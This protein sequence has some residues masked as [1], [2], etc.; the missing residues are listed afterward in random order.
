M[1]DRKL[2]FFLVLLL[3]A[4]AGFLV[5]GCNGNGAQEILSIQVGESPRTEYFTNEPLDV[6]GGTITVNY[7]K[8]NVT[9]E[10]SDPGV[11]FSGFESY[12]AGTKRVT[13]EYSGFKAYFNVTVTDPEIDSVE[14][15]TLPAQ[16]E[17]YVQDRI[18]VS[19][20]VLLVKFSSGYTLDV[21]MNSGNVTLE[22]DFGKAAVQTDVVV[23]Y[24]GIPVSFPVKVLDIY[25]RSIQ[26]RT[27]PKTVYYIDES[28][29][30][31]EGRLAL[32]Y[33]NGTEKI[34]SLDDDAVSV[35]E[36]DTS[37]MGRHL[38]NVK[39]GSFRTD[40]SVAVITP[41]MAYVYTH[42]GDIKTVDWNQVIPP[43]E[44]AEAAAAIALVNS[45][46]ELS[47]EEKAFF[48][49]GERDGILGAGFGAEFAAF[50]T[51]YADFSS[52]LT[53]DLFLYFNFGR[54]AEFEAFVTDINNY[55]EHLFNKYEKKY[56]DIVLAE[57][58]YKFTIGDILETE[59]LEYYDLV[60]YDYS[61]MLLALDIQE[62]VAASPLSP[63][64]ITG[65]NFTDFAFLGEASDIIA[66]Y[67][68]LMLNDAWPLLQL[69]TGKEFD[70]Y[71]FI[72]IVNE[73][74]LMS[75]LNEYPVIYLAYLL[76]DAYY[77]FQ[78]GYMF[79]DYTLFLY[80]YNRFEDEFNAAQQAVRDEFDALIYE[81]GIT[82]RDLRGELT[83]LFDSVFAEI[84]PDETLW[85]FGA[86]FADY[87]AAYKL[88]DLSAADYRDA[89]D[90]LSALFAG[91]TPEQKLCFNDIMGAAYVEFVFEYYKQFLNPAELQIY[92]LLMFASEQHYTDTKY[93][94]IDEIPYS[95]FIPAM[96]ACIDAYD[97]LAVKTN[98]DK[99]FLDY[100]NTYKAYYE[101][102]TQNP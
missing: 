98:F 82:Y 74:L 62:A 30:L 45:Y 12:T 89:V 27:A 63:R 33:N 76:D 57:R 20:G 52:F 80:C 32:L 59:V 58:P 44:P 47:A 88:S 35:D 93:K 60:V 37:A 87:Y 42:L 55:K 101:A 92:E 40:L 39:Y 54:V 43:F 41:G 86:A 83:E 78:L 81:D 96:A 3:A 79:D 7:D 70:V 17:Y 65:G 10:M 64:A 51:R 84:M 11:T 94:D 97:A 50:M 48:T 15:K 69:W 53:S 90:T 4:L 19:D 24:A 16:R 25:I 102:L 6:S 29:D 31:T 1:K 61:V 21:P 9:V 99:Y 28:R 100:Y 77:Y 49:K 36:F 22:Y 8:K 72:D 2:Q 23:R 46:L 34:I 67:G 56:G 13:A 5:A 75:Y 14:I 68:E 18:K 38:L 26:I 71:T 95:Y 66:A 91:F 85:A 73:Y